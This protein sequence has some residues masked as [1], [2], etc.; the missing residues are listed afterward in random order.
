MTFPMDIAVSLGK[1][2]V[3]EW[4]HQRNPHFEFKSKVIKKAAANGHIDVIHFLLLNRTEGNAQQALHSA[5]VNGQIKVVEFLLEH[6]T[7]GKLKKGKKIFKELCYEGNYSMI[8]WMIH[9]R[10][11]DCNFK[12]T[13]KRK[14][15]YLPRVIELLKKASSTKK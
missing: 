15:Q 11:K 6:H 8:E 5:I 10:P 3:V 9:N 12:L 7:K 4:L 1:L 2:D 13:F 14:K